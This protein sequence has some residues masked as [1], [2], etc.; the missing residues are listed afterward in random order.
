MAWPEN[1]VR[2]DADECD[3][4]YKDDLTALLQREADI[5]TRIEARHDSADAEDHKAR[6]ML[7][8]GEHRV[9]DVRACMNE[10]T[11]LRSLARDDQKEIDAIDKHLAAPLNVTDLIGSLRQTKSNHP[12]PK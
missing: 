7:H 8:Q 10:A 6:M 4:K 1:T 12:T 11:R 2:A 9:K 5:Q 3:T